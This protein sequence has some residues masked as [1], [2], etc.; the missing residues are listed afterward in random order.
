M[1]DYFNK[2]KV[3]MSAFDGR[4]IEKQAFIC[5]I[6]TNYKGNYVGMLRMYDM[7]KREVYTVLEKEKFSISDEVIEY[8]LERIPSIT[9][10]KSGKER[11][12]K[13]GDSLTVICDNIVSYTV[14]SYSGSIKEI[15]IGEAGSLILCNKITN[16]QYTRDGIAAAYD[17]D[18]PCNT[19]KYKAALK[20]AENKRNMA[21]LGK[22]EEDGNGRLENI[23]SDRSGDYTIPDCIRTIGGI[24]LKE[25]TENTRV[26]F[27]ANT[28]VSG[29]V[30]TYITHMEIKNLMLLYDV[31]HRE[32]IRHPKLDIT[33]SDIDSMEETLAL[34][35]IRKLALD[36]T[37]FT[38]S[39]EMWEKVIKAAYS[40]VSDYAYGK[41]EYSS[42]CAVRRAKG[43]DM[44]LPEGF[45]AEK[46]L[47]ASIY[48]MDLISYATILKDTKWMEIHRGKGIYAGQAQYNISNESIDAYSLCGCDELI[49]STAEKIYRKAGAAVYKLYTGS[50]EELAAA[51]RK[52]KRDANAV[53]VGAV[54][55]IKGCGIGVGVLPEVFMLYEASN[56]KT[57][58]TRGYTVS[59]SNDA[60]I[61]VKEIGDIIGW[62]NE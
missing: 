25:I 44:K 24:S 39:S 10:D 13:D 41:C 29:D 2:A 12:C 19:E 27:G 30:S 9:I 58:G 38:M 50:E 4:R 60:Y 47:D 49:E 26:A 7:E 1:Y 48:Y 15:S 57:Y 31:L 37:D 16:M 5:M 18:I 34:E 43:E 52:K 35:V 56:G 28:V 11:I 6:H 20:R 36:I 33:V 21:G 61:K 42:G 54:K 53:L 55:I 23:C 8:S 22:F 14:C 62:S 3:Y 40:L 45:N 46:S 17:I 51:R 32:N 59:T